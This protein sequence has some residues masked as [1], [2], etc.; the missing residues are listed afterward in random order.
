MSLPPATRPARLDAALKAPELDLDAALGFG[1][2]LLAG[3]TIARPHDMAIAA[4]IGH[5]TI[6]GLDARDLSAR[7]K[8]DAGGLQ[9]DRLSVADLGGA[10]FRRAAASPRAVAAGQRRVDL[11]APDM[12]PVTALLSRFAPKAAGVAWPRRAGHGAGQAACQLTVQ[13]DAPRRNAK[14]AVDGSLGKVRLALNGETHGDL[15]R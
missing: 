3:S 15:A 11:D 2:A 12:T 8:M 7:L 4:D 6:A 10:A 1:K 13:G 9:I 14:L 5:A